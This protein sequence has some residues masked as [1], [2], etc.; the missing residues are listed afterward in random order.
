[1]NNKF[2]S[3]VKIASLFIFLFQKKN[4]YILINKYSTLKLNKKENLLPEIYYILIVNTLP[5]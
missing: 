5:L 4:I 2:V 1:M 3:G